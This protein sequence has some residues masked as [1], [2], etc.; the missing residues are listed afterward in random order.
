MSSA[1]TE[2][3]PDPASDWERQAFLDA[4]FELVAE[5]AS[6]D[7]LQVS[8]LVVRSGR[9]NASFYRIFGSKEGLLLAVVE[10]AVRRAVIIVERRMREARTPQQAVRAW[11]RELLML[12]AADSAGRVPAIAIDRF[13]LLRRFPDADATIADPLRQLL[14]AVLPTSAR[15]GRAVLSEAAFEL[16]LSRQASWIALGH[17]PTPREINAYA[18][19]VVRLVGLPED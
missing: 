18:A 14:R 17:V 13:R 16:I 15:P 4:A 7:D 19:L 1:S 12:A 6:L 5:S 8:Q 2:I 9:H 10:E 3:E 11:S